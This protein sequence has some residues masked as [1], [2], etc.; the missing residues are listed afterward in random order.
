M[1]VIEYFFDKVAP[2]IIVLITV[3][4]ILSLFNCMP[5]PK[6]ADYTSDEYPCY[7][8]DLCVRSNAYAKSHVQDC[9]IAM[10]KCFRYKDYDKCKAEKDFDKCWNNIGVRN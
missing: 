5:M 6:K 3:I 1:K 8:A 10:Q 7:M 4:V 2:V 9:T